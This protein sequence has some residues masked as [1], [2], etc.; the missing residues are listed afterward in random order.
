MQ[1]QQASRRKAKIKLGLQSPSGGGKTMSALL[2]AYGLCGDWSKVAVIESST[3]II[4]IRLI[5]N[6]LSVPSLSRILKR[7]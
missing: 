7:P 2:I 1:L 6:I 5:F 3:T 4:A